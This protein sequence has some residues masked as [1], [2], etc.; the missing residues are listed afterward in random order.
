MLDPKQPIAIFAEATI[1]LLNAKM[2]EG[3]L[4]YGRNHVVGVI[5][6]TQAGKTIRDICPIDS[7]VPII[8][9][10]DEAFAKGAQVLVLGTAPSGGRV[11]KD[12]MM[13]L[14]DAVAAG[15]SVVNGMHDLMI[16]V[17]L[18]NP[19]DCAV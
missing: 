3:I 14:R 11:P 12:W 19:L 1:G 17:S 4:R 18:V 16:V 8:A 9:T 2:A 10:L 7:D 6:S 5:Y 13:M 15:L